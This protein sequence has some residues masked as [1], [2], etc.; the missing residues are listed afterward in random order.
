MAGIIPVPDQ[1]L[2]SLVSFQK[3]IFF[4][5][6]KKI[7]PRGGGDPSFASEVA[8]WIPACAGTTV[9]L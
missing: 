3:R 9:L 2:K 1:A 7:R 4:A 8:T 5:V 6:A